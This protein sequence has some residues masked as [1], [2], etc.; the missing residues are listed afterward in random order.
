MI[1]AKL[2]SKCYLDIYSFSMDFLPVVE[3]EIVMQ[4]SAQ[5]CK[6]TLFFNNSF[7]NTFT[8]FHTID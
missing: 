8:Y 5:N 6:R 4:I 3:A 2:K 1:F 7:E